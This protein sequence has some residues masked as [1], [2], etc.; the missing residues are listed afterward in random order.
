[1]VQILHRLASHERTLVF[2]ISGRDQAFLEEHKVSILL[3]AS[4]SSLLLQSSAEHGYFIKLP[5]DDSLWIETNPPSSLNQRDT[6]ALDWKQ[7]AKPILD[8]YTDMTPGMFIS[9][10]YSHAVCMYVSL[11]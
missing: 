4:L 10:Y 1:M 2:I 9:V 6:N 8:K 7:Y 5:G 3:H 11:F